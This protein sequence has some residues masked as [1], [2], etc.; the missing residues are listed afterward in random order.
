VVIMSASF[1]GKVA[2][3]TDVGTSIGAATARLLAKG[4]ARDT[5]WPSRQAQ[6][7]REQRR[8]PRWGLSAAA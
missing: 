1:E 2:L 6:P 5:F 4:A 7:R 3:V 8:D